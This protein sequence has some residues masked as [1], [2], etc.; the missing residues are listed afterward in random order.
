MRALF[1]NDPGRLTA[2][3]P[4]GQADRMD[5]ALA[6]GIDPTLRAEL[7]ALVGQECV[8][9]RATDLVR[10]ASDASPYRRT[11]RAVVAPRTA[12]QVAAVLRHCA[13]RGLNA[14][15]RAGGTSLSG[16]S[17]CDGVLID[18]RQHWSGMQVE[19]DGEQL[20]VRPGTVL[21]HANTV[22]ARHGRRLGPDPASARAA[23]I[24][25]VVANNA[26]GMR[27]RLERSAYATLRE[28][29]FVTASG[30]LVNTQEPGAEER[31]RTAEPALAAGLMAIREEILAEP[32][33]VQL[34]RR[35]YS[36]RN[37]TGYTMRAFLDGTTPLEIF[38]RLLVGSEG[39]L[40]FIAEVV[41]DTLPLPAVSGICWV[42]LPDTA[43]AVDF[44]AQVRELGPE[45][46]EMMMSTSL[47]TA[48]ARMPEAPQA[49]ADLPPNAVSL[50]VEFGAAD[51]EELDRLEAATRKLAA[52]HGPLLPVQMETSAAFQRMSWKIRSGLSTDL[53][54]NKPAGAVNVN[55]DVG[56]PIENLGPAVLDLAALLRQHGFSDQ[57]VGHAA[58]GNMHF[59]L[60]AHLDTD[61]GR[62][63]YAAFMEDFVH[64]VVDVYGGSLKAEH[65]TG[66]N[67]APF[68]ERE[69]GPRITE[70]MWRLRRLADPRQVLGKDVLLSQ[71]EQVHLLSFKHDPVAHPLLD[72]CVE[73]GFC[74]PVCPSRNVTTTPR[75]RI[76]LWREMARQEERSPLVTTLLEEYQ[77]EAIDTCAVDSSCAE[78]CPYG[79]DTG[80]VM[81]QLRAQ[82]KSASA[83]RIATAVGEH[84]SPAQRVARAAVVVADGVQQRVGTAPLQALTGVARRAVS[85]DLLPTVPGPMP[86]AARALPVTAPDQAA[87]VYFPACVNRIFG[88]DPGVDEPLG[89]AD[90]L[91]EVSARAGRPVWIPGDVQGECCGTP[92]GSKGFT[93]GRDRRQQALAEAL[94][95]WSDEGRLPV[96][97][98]ATSCTHAVVQEIPRH[99]TGELAERFARVRVL[100][101]TVWASEL[102]PDLQVQST[103][104]QI[105]VHPGCSAAH[106]GITDDLARLAGA[107]AE[108]VHIPMA[109][110][111]CGT[112]GDRGLLHPELVESA[113]RQERQDLGDSEVYASANRTCEMGL[114]QATGKPFESLVITLERLTR[115][116]AGATPDPLPD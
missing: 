92:W 50:L 91:V 22:L 70:M 81:K 19:N 100:D 60:A 11:P 7:V 15:F 65:G 59:T 2:P 104:G 101:A 90:A 102:L 49:W 84:W 82:Q 75:Q 71:T 51:S 79:I 54:L 68:V 99:L 103:V 6:R 37:T 67:M 66:I 31:F 95:R 34:L 89:L 38:K 73:C 39:T 48:A 88:R 110:A 116:E 96:V 62:E 115:P 4:L 8:L 35:K 64:L 20:R 16:Q 58:Y 85:K 14:T 55:E 21:E 52:A 69:W 43:T 40:A 83:Q 57:V 87:A 36:I 47:V 109:S 107:L 42:H 25:G 93:K 17:Q 26:A 1:E 108:R 3:T 29:T 94:L 23:C 97:V 9:D 46:V 114:R 10:Y 32:E 33:L 41:L 56:F 12:E 18:V 106:L 80:A 78:A 24:G 27:C 113:T 63:R 61:E 44:V 45:A 105:T 53:A 77:Y 72:G 30:T 5:P 13:D 112:A 98:D 86:R 111:C 74:E 76:A 28:V